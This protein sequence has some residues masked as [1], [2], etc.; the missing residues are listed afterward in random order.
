MDNAKFTNIWDKPN[1]ATIGK[2]MIPNVAK[3]GKKQVYQNLPKLAVEHTC[4]ALFYLLC[5]AALLKILPIMLKLMLNIYLLCSNYAQY[6][7]LS[8]HVFLVN[9]HFMGKQ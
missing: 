5:Y 1:F 3:T 8:S 7:Y 4:E 9:L 2:N 6:L